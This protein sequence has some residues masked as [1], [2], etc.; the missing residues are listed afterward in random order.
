MKK[1]IVAVLALS[2]LLTGCKS[3]A[4]K[5]TEKLIDSIGTVSIE[6]ESLINEAQESYDYLTERQKEQVNNYQILVNA[7]KE[8]DGFKYIDLAERIYNKIQ[9]SEFNFET[10]IEFFSELITKS[11]IFNAENI[12]AIASSTDSDSIQIRN[13]AEKLYNEFENMNV[14]NEELKK[15]VEEYYVAYE[16]LCDFL[17]DYN[18]TQANF[19]I[20]A[21]SCQETYQLKKDSL[22]SVI[23]SD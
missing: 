17:L 1:S 18:F 13:E 15:A 2:I 12:R 19:K 21:D 8:L 9:E 11:Y 23:N 10:K 6:S 4:V 14:E 22:N 3:E 5:N 16:Q 7:Q 20:L